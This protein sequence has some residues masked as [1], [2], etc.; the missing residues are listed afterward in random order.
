MNNYL[1]KN[2]VGASLVEITL[3]MGLGCILLLGFI[4]FYANLSK[5][6]NTMLKTIRLE[7]E[8]Q[9][10]LHFMQQDI[11]RAGYNAKALEFV[12]GNKVNPFTQ[13]ADIDLQV[14]ESHCVLYSYDYNK[15]GQVTALNTQPV[16]DR[17]GFRLHNGVI[18][19]RAKSDSSFSCRQ[20]NWHNLTEPNVIKVE[21]LQFKLVQSIKSHITSRKVYISITGS[22]VSD[23]TQRRTFNSMVK[24]RNDKYS[25]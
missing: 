6:S 9:G 17:F 19:S 16:D 12:A 18:Q 21:N 20:G 2:L 14:P 22:L 3:G 10:A 15:T 25:A 11:R 5:A 24:I 23:S 13:Q 7:H 4:S 1:S 8:L